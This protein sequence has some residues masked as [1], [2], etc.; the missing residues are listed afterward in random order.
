MNSTVTWR[1]SSYILWKWKY[2]PI[3]VLVSAFFSSWRQIYFF[4]WVL[5]SD[6]RT[7]VIQPLKQSIGCSKMVLGDWGPSDVGPTWRLG[8]RVPYRRGPNRRLSEPGRQ[9]GPWGPNR[10]LRVTNMRDTLHLLEQG[11]I[12]FYLYVCANNSFLV[13]LWGQTIDFGQ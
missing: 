10:R 3:Y 6:F 7:R 1:I 2:M 13:W 8:P 11:Y 12:E 5:E 4:T 9:S